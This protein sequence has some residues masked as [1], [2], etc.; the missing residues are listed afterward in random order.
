MKYETLADLSFSS[1]YFNYEQTLKEL[2]RLR[3][4]FLVYSYIKF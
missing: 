1:Y 2:N 3:L 4:I